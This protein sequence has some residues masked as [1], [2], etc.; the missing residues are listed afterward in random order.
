[1]TT[2]PPNKKIDANGNP[3]NGAG[4]DATN[5]QFVNPQ[6]GPGVDDA[7]Y[8]SVKYAPIWVAPVDGQKATYAASINGL[9]LASSATDI[10][11][12]K[13]SATKTVRIR[14]LRISGIKTTAGAQVIF[15]LIKRSA[16]NTG[17]TSTA[18]ALVPYDSASAAATAVIAAYTANPSGLGTAVGTLAVD[19][20]YIPLATE[21]AAPLSY[22]FGDGPSSTIVLR[23]TS[24]FLALN[25]NGVTVGGGA[26]DIWVELTEE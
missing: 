18:P 7:T 2:L 16:A 23:G 14:K 17:G 21:N 13:G 19:S 9:A 25:L 26:L 20:V 1:M 10:F 12:I 8:S 5:H 24:Q 6:A 3:L 11:T 22:N 15:Q 4:W